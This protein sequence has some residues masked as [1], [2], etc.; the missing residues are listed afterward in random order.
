MSF[1]PNNAPTG[2]PDEVLGDDDNGGADPFDPGGDPNQTEGGDIGGGGS[3]DGGGSDG[4]DDTQQTDFGP[5]VD[6]DP[7][8]QATDLDPSDPDPAPTDGDQASEGGDIGDGGSELPGEGT[9]NPGAPD[10]G[11]D[12]TTD[13]DS[14]APDPAPTE[15]EQAAE[16]ADDPD[17]DVDPTPDTAAAFN[18]G[19]E[20]GRPV[21]TPSADRTDTT[22]E[23]GATIGS[24]A[25]ETARE[26]S[27]GPGPQVSPREVRMSFDRF[28]RPTSARLTEDAVER[29]FRASPGAAS[30]ENPSIR[31]TGTFAG[32]PGAAS[33]D[34]DPTRTFPSAPLA[35]GATRRQLDEGREQVRDAELADGTIQER[36]RGD[37]PSSPAAARAAALEAA[38]NRVL[39]TGGSV[40]GPPGDIEQGLYDVTGDIAEAG[41]EEVVDPASDVLGDIFGARAEAEAFRAGVGDAEA[42]ETAGE[43]VLRAPEGEEGDPGAVEAGTETFAEGAGDITVSAVQAPEAIRN[44]GVLGFDASKF[45]AENPGLAAPAA[46]GFA[47]S[48]LSQAYEYAAENPVRTA[49]QLGGS[50]LVMGGAAAASS[51]AG[52]ATRAAIQPGE[53]ALGYGGSAAFRGA[54]SAA[55]TAGDVVPGRAGQAVAG[56]GSGL[57]RAG[58]TLFPNNEP[59]LISEEAGLAAIGRVGE[60]ARRTVGGTRDVLTGETRVADVAPTQAG[61]LIGRF[62]PGGATGVEGETGPPGGVSKPLGGGGTATRDVESRSVEPGEV[63]DDTPGTDFAVETETRRRL[64]IS[65]R[66]GAGLVPPRVELETE[67]RQRPA[68]R[69]RESQE[70]EVDPDIRQD[71]LTQYQDFLR[72]YA[73]QELESRREQVDPLRGPVETER[74]RT[75]EAQRP[76]TERSEAEAERGRAGAEIRGDVMQDQF[77]AP[78]ADLRAAPFVAG[79]GRTAVG[80]DLDQELDLEQEVESETEQELESEQDVEAE[81]E[82]EGEPFVEIEPEPEPEVEPE[83]EPEQEVE[84][85]IFPEQDRDEGEEF[86]FAAPAS[87][88]IITDFADPL[89]GELRETDR[90]L[91]F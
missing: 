8:D 66:A 88:Q 72:P 75:R 36:G 4:D 16:G 40:L 44:V 30:V 33:S 28:S 91:P 50:V 67:T 21:S 19:R 18:Q 48:R 61:E 37:L 73:E 23:S 89:S 24:V 58:Q 13:P 64:N 86:L 11:E 74:E 62:R 55:E 46:A 15:G 54:A 47:A 39:P 6:A 12:A 51:R 26:A 42:V 83:P 29:Q 68:E 35:A 32:S 14:T 34:I 27:R 81:P 77:T 79:R 84:G 25:A 45:T 5:P 49:G 43:D 69:A 87:G 56:T 9:A 17:A 1:D 20:F 71:A 41:Q 90:D 76:F 52:L 3:D 53:E 59:L 38:T 85:E 65:P 80:L 63:E 10:P 60:G 2:S 70:P 31:E 78:F 22:P 57:R 82:T 7:D